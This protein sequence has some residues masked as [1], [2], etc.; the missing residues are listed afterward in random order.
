[1]RYEKLHE[2]NQL[3]AVSRAVHAKFDASSLGPQEVFTPAA[4]HCRPQCQGSDTVM[5][6]MGI[7]RFLSR[8]SPTRRQADCSIKQV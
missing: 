8:L 1:M 2:S 4:I 3:I 5:E 6:V 7:Q